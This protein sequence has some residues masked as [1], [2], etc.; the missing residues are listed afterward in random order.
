MHQIDH[1]NL[2][3]DQKKS[4][5]IYCGGL[6]LCL[7]EILKKIESHLSGIHFLLLVNQMRNHTRSSCCLELFRVLD[8]SLQNQPNV[9]TNNRLDAYLL[10]YR[11]WI[12]QHIHEPSLLC[13]H[14]VDTFLKLK[15]MTSFLLFP[16]ITLFLFDRSILSYLGNNV[17]LHEVICNHGEF[18][19]AIK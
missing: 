2:L 15:K 12:Y 18:T 14:W 1:P 19:L 17:L 10:C 4:R 16:S 5:L 3:K 13:I 6:H 7:G 8:S 11:A 9:A